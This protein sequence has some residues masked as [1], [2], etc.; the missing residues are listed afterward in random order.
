MQ[1]GLVFLENAL[2]VDL[3]SKMKIA[4]LLDCLQQD[5]SFSFSYPP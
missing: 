1:I 2:S 5:P 4:V 3:T